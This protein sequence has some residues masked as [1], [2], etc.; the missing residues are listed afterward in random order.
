MTSAGPDLIIEA[1]GTGHDRAGFACG[2][3]AL[4]RYFQ[5]QAGQDMRRRVARVFVCCDRQSGG[6]A[7]FYTLSALSVDATA[8]GESAFRRLP[9]HPIPAALIGRLAVDH[10]WQG[11]GIGRLLLVDAL[12]RTQAVSHQIAIHAVVVDAKDDKAAAFY[13]LFGFH[14]FA[15]TPNRLF[16]PLTQPIRP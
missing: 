1:L 15:E 16:L 4:D 12:A 6:L 5:H 9:R 13:R 14:P 8:A 2:T 3:P 10:R 11:Q 7:G